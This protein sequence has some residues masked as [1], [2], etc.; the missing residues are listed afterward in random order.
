MR[1]MCGHM[2]G[3]TTH[4]AAQVWMAPNV[5]SFYSRVDCATPVAIRVATGVG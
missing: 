4:E 5:W 3:T 1:H 2:C